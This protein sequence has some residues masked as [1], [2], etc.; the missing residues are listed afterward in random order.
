MM[1]IEEL[2]F[3]TLLSKIKLLTEAYSEPS[4]KS[5]MELFA[6]SMAKRRWLFSHKSHLRCLAWF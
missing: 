5:K 4:Q 6:K 1:Y 3:Y 2:Y